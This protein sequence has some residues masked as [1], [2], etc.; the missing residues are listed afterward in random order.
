MLILIYSTQ[1]CVH[2]HAL[3]PIIIGHLNRTCVYTIPTPGRKKSPTETIDAYKLSL[4]FEKD[5]ST[6][7]GFESFEKYCARVTISVALYA[8]TLQSTPWNSEAEPPEISVVTL[9]SWFAAV[10][11]EPP[12]LL[13]APILLAAL[14]VAGFE[15][16]RVFKRQF[17][18]ILVVILKDVCPR[19]SQDTKTGSAA[20]AARLGNF[21]QA[22]FDHGCTLNEPEGRVLRESQVSEADEEQDTRDQHSSSSSRH[23]HHSVG[24]GRGRGRGRRY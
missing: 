9:W 20:A 17:H 7:D 12:H 16:L 10:V 19:L 23:S 3:G 4:G 21:V 2:T 11:N 15:L 13:T 6:P 22:Y 18:K 1:V 5:A 14:E 8:A 24:R